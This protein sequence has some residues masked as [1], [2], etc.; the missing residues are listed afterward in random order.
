MRSVKKKNRSTKKMVLIGLLIVAVLIA[1]G[2]AFKLTRSSQTTITTDDGQT[3]NLEPATEEEKQQVDDNKR[4]IVENDEKNKSNQP[5]AGTK[6]QVSAVITA[7]SVNGINGYVTGVF[8]EGGTCRA[9]FTMNG[10][11][12]SKTSTGFQNASYT[13]CAPITTTPADFPASGKWSV[14]L[15]YTSNTSEGA[16]Q[17]Q[18]FEVT[19]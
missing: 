19:K 7:A 2:V 15:V 3:V 1:G 13:Q 4:A 5:P 9:E 8:E 17:S 12:F 10:S 16:S 14:K 18:T 11:S 6:R